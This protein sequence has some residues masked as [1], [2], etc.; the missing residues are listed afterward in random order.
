MNEQEI[1]INYVLIDSSYIKKH[2]EQTKQSR[3]I[4]KKNWNQYFT[5]LYNFIYILISIL[6]IYLYI[7][8]YHK[9]K[10]KF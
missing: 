8:Y 1:D 7:L 2:I 5:K 3:P 10:S 4:P 9:E 6:A